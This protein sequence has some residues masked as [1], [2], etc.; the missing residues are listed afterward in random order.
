MTGWIVLGVWLVGLPVAWW[1]MTIFLLEDDQRAYP[2]LWADPV[3]A[4]G[5]RV[6]SSLLAAALMSFWP[7]IVLLAPFVWAFNF[8]GRSRLT[9]TRWEREQA[10]IAERERSRRAAREAG[11]PPLPR[12]EDL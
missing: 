1:R 5:E 11:L 9:A 4:R 3:Y 10:E 6:V 2:D 7:V 12:D 8:L